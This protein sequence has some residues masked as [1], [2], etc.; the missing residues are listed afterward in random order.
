MLLDTMKTSGSAGLTE[1]EVLVMDNNSSDATK[2]VV[3]EYTSLENPVFRHLLESKP[4]KSRALNA[5]IRTCTMNHLPLSTIH[6]CRIGSRRN[7]FWFG[8]S[9]TDEPKSGRKGSALVSGDPT[10]LPWYPKNDGICLPGRALRWMCTLNPQRRFFRKCYASIMAG[11]I[12]E[13]YRLGRETKLQRAE[14]GRTAK[15][16]SNAQPG[17]RTG[18]S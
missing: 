12:V 11:Q 4:G 17:G 7:I 13:S 9:I 14:P 3:A 15:L 1:T 2:Q 8:G 10:T 6:F 18:A 5:G 16:R